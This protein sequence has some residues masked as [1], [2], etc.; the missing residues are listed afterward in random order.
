MA[1]MEKLRLHP[2]QTGGA[3]ADRFGAQDTAPKNESEGGN[4]E[5]GHFT[6][7]SGH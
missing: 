2:V 7:L 6:S 1:S 4:G 5:M 3:D